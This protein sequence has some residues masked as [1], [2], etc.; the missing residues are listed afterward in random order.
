MLNFLKIVFADIRTSQIK[1]SD[2]LRGFLLEFLLVLCKCFPH[3][4]ND[5]IFEITETLINLTKNYLEAKHI[6]A[7]LASF[8]DKYTMKSNAQKTMLRSFLK[9]V[10]NVSTVQFEKITSDKTLSKII[11]TRLNEIE[12][13]SEAPQMSSRRWF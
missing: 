5:E 6:K 13:G 1:K 2:V 8:I 4:L 7:I 11:I 12:F 9:M 3:C 10:I